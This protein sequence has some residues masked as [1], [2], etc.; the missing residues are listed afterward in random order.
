MRSLLLIGALLTSECT[1]LVNTG[2]GDLRFWV[3]GEPGPGGTTLVIRL[4]NETERALTY[5]L[6]F[7]TL[8]RR[9]ADGWDTA[10]EG[11]A[12]GTCPYERRRL[13]AG[14]SADGSF[15]LS[16]SLSAGTYRLTTSARFEGDSFSFRVAT[17]DFTL[18]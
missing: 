1:I 12:G 10:Q 18:K 5:N 13:E 9:S 4:S 6:C 7:S 14:A 8:E 16:D 11:P 15:A 17:P 3:I 2:T